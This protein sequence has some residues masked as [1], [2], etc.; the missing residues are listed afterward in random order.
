MITNY[1]GFDFV[2]CNGMGRVEGV[3]KQQIRSATWLFHS[4]TKSAGKLVKRF[5]FLP[6]Y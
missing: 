4:D 6:I 5:C 1:F 2:I 3:S